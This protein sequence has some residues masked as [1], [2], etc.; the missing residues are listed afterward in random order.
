MFDSHSIAPLDSSIK[1]ITIKSR[2]CDTVKFPNFG[3]TPK[4]YTLHEDAHSSAILSMEDQ[5]RGRVHDSFYQFSEM[6]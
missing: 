6:Y 4:A 1:S 2:L 5:L 3:E